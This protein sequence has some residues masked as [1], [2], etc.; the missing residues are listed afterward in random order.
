MEDSLNNS[1]HLEIAGNVCKLDI[2]EDYTYIYNMLDDDED[3]FLKIDTPT[4]KELMLEWKKEFDA[5]SSH[6]KS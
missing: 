2:S 5:C 3:I 4:L 1:K 6:S